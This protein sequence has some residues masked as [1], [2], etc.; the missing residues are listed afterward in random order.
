MLD[1]PV[2]QYGDKNEVDGAAVAAF[3][4][5]V[6]CM[7]AGAYISAVIERVRAMP[8]GGPGAKLCPA[9]GS[10]GRRAGT[11]SSMNF[12][13][14]FGKAKCVLEVLGIDYARA[15]PVV[16]KRS[17]GLIGAEKDAARILAIKLYP[18]A[19]DRLRRKK[20]IG[21][22]DALLI[23]RWYDNQQLGRVAA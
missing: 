2:M 6:R 17:M 7:H 1:M 12:G 19:E 20:D 11:Q 23:A 15:E 22:A 18:D 4:R 16:W 10:G 3:I 8:P 21:R 5:E 9:C 13:D 14:H